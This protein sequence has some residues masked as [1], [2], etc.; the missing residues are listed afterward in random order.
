MEYLDMLQVY[1]VSLMPAIGVLIYG[2]VSTVK[3]VKNYKNLR[4]EVMDEAAIQQ[5]KA[6]NK[7]LQAMCRDLADLQR[8][9]KKDTE[10]LIR[11]M[12]E[13]NRAIHRLEKRLGGSGNDKEI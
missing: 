1:L 11:M 8:A 5:I 6:E 10:Q 2:I 4:A 12:E 3:I 9:D 13:Q 7:R